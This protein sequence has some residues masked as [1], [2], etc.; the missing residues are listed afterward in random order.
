MESFV[1]I[2]PAAQLCQ[3]PVHYV[4]SPAIHFPAQ[5]KPRPS[6]RFRPLRC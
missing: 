3:V 6:P 2:A 1:G 5:G 4:L